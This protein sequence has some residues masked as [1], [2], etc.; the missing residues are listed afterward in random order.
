MISKRWTDASAMLT[1]HWRNGTR[2]AALPEALRPATRDE[3]Y[4]IQAELMH[5]TRQPLFGWKIAATSLAG[6]KHIN[7]DG[8]LAGR[9]LAEN[10]RPIGATIPLANT[11][12]RVAEV[13]FAF[14]LARDLPPRAG[15]Y[16]QAEVMAAIG[17]LHPAIEVPNSRF[18]DFTQV[19]APS[20]I[21]DDACAHLF[22]LGA[23]HD[24]DWR[25]LDLAAWRVSALV[26]G[27]VRHDG[28]GANVLG[29][30]RIAMTWIANELSRHGPGLKAGEV[31]TTGTCLTPIAVSPGDHVT[32]DF[33]RLGTIDARFG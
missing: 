14:R 32:A 30:P 5:S 33:G 19:G 6:Q 13:E 27:V 9:I 1:A 18:D 24:P 11:L 10:V 20:L 7:V 31:V 28:I 8:P 15:T 21:A 25:D 3:G 29:D 16:S 23:A 2:I 4:A 17:S 26:N 22:M 12:M